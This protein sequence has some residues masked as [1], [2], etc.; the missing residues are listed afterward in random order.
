MSAG[1]RRFEPFERF[2]LVSV[3]LLAVVSRS[4]YAF[5][6]GFGAGTEYLFDDALIT[7]RYARNL[8]SGHG[9]VYNQ[10]E[11]VLGT[12]SP[13]YA[14]IVA[15]PSVLGCDPI[16]SALLINIGC[17]ILICWLLVYLARGWRSMQVLAPIFF[18]LQ[19]NILFWSGTGMEFSLLIL[20]CLATISLFAAD[21]QR[22]AGLIAALALIGRVD[23]VIVFAGFA[24]VALLSLRKIPWPFLSTLTA[25][26]VP[27]VLFAAVCYGDPV[28]LS[29]RARYQIYA[30]ESWSGRALE[31]LWAQPWL[32]VGLAGAALAW[33]DP[34]KSAPRLAFVLRALS[35]HPL[36][37]LLAYEISGGPIYRRYQ[38]ALDASLAVLAAWACATLIMRI[39]QNRRQAWAWTLLLICGLTIARPIL[40]GLRFP[41]RTIDPPLNRV[42]LE[43]GRWLAKNTA[44]DAL[45][46]AGNIGYLGYFSERRIFDINGLVSR[47]AY[48]ARLRNDDLA[49][50]FDQ[51]APDYVA[52]D[53]AERAQLEAHLALRHYRLVHQ[54]SHPQDSKFTYA[55]FASPSAR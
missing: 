22:A 11:A 44:P 50:V 40:E 49:K 36:F 32:L 31:I 21:C 9:L 23:A 6:R 7:L 39:G 15:L 33:L 29:A 8:A 1:A 28:P 30:V 54:S 16:I 4:A 14:A 19:T 25:G 37:F 38:V 34:P 51:A 45:V 53:P 48:E 10:G 24:V 52:L 3:A 18:L 26:I 43:T 17:D 27:W 47:S 42:H 20:L 41:W 12:S 46:L 55:V 13:L 2:W 35:L 5:V